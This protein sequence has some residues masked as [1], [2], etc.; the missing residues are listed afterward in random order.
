MTIA[1]LD[2]GPGLAAL[3]AWGGQVAAYGA[4]NQTVVDKVPPDMLHMVDP[5]WFVKIAINFG[6]HITTLLQL[7]FKTDDRFIFCPGTNFH[8]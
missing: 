2:P 4:S 3:Q 7:E 8:L 6:L 1:S 5:H